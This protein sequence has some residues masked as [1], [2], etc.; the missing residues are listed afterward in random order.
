MYCSSCTSRLLSDCRSLQCGENEI[1]GISL[2]YD[3]AHFLCCSGRVLALRCRLPLDA[4][5][6]GHFPVAF[7]LQPLALQST[8]NHCYAM[9]GKHSDTHFSA[10]NGDPRADLTEGMIRSR[11]RR[12]WKSR[13]AGFA[14]PT[15]PGRRR[16]RP[17]MSRPRRATVVGR[18]RRP[19]QAG[20]PFSTSPCEGRQRWGEESTIRGEQETEER[21]T[22]NGDELSRHASQPAEP[23]QTQP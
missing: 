13:T 20:C 1:M 17:R 2:D 16:H 10:H 7:Q 5:P 18:S 15:R 6:A 12:R 3:H 8:V 14:P 23:N 9:R 22:S 21:N 19:C 11:L 4:A